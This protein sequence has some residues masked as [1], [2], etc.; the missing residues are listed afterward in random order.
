[1]VELGK[2]LR[3][4][5]VGV[6]QELEALLRHPGMDGTHPWLVV[7][8]RPPEVQHGLH[9][10]PS[11]GSPYSAFTVSACADPFPG[12]RTGPTPSTWSPSRYG[13]WPPHCP[14]WRSPRS[15]RSWPT[16]QRCARP[17]TPR[18]TMPRTASWSP[19]G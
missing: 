6:E 15:T 7:G 14:V 10:H 8:P 13:H 11:P 5:P 12:S 2:D 9:P 4:L 16:P 19:G 1:G 3:P 17:M 18:R